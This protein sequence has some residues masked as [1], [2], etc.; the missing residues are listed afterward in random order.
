MKS[1]LQWHEDWQDAS[2]G[3]CAISAVLSTVVFM[4]NSSLH[5]TFAR[6]QDVT[7]FELARCHLASHRSSMWASACVYSVFAI[8]S[9]STS[10]TL[11]ALLHSI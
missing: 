10:T 6:V 11:P 5:H 7:H 9:V 1:A 8:A 4:G 3:G 2:V